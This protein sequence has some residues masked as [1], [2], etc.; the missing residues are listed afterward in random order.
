MRASGFFVNFHPMKKFEDLSTY[1]PKKLRTLRNNLNNR[2]AHF[3]GHGDGASDLRS[4]HKLHGLDEVECRE[5]LKEVT[6]LLSNK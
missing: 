2:I 3:E 4:S 6:K 5:L 1:S